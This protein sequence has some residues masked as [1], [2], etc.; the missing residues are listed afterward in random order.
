MSDMNHTSQATDFQ[1]YGEQPMSPRLPDSQQLQAQLMASLTPQ[2]TQGQWSGQLLSSNFETHTSSGQNQSVAKNRNS[3]DNCHQ[4]NVSNQFPT[5]EGSDNFFVTNLTQINDKS[6]TRTGKGQT[7]ATRRSQKIKQILSERL[8]VALDKNKLVKIAPK[9]S[10]QTEACSIQDAHSKSNG[11]GNITIKKPSIMPATASHNTALDI[12]VHVTDLPLGCHSRG[13]HIT[14]VS[15]SSSLLADLNSKASSETEIGSLHKVIPHNSN[16]I[17][18][19]NPSNLNSRSVLNQ[20]LPLGMIQT[21]PALSKVDGS[22][23]SRGHHLGIQS[24]GATHTPVIANASVLGETSMPNI[25]LLSQSKGVPISATSSTFSF[26]SGSGLKNTKPASEQIM[27]Q[28]IPLTMLQTLPSITQTTKPD[29]VN[30]GVTLGSTI[31]PIHLNQSGTTMS[32][33]QQVSNNITQLSPGSLS[34]MAL[35]NQLINSDSFQLEKQKQTSDFQKSNL[36]PSGHLVEVTETEFTTQFEDEMTPNN[37][38]QNINAATENCSFPHLNS[39]REISPHLSE[40]GTHQKVSNSENVM[41]TYQ[42]LQSVISSLINGLQGQ[43]DATRKLYSPTCILATN[44]PQP[45]ASNQ[46]GN[47]VREQTLNLTNSNQL[48]DIPYSLVPINS[49][50]IPISNS[51]VSNASQSVE[52]MKDQHLSVDSGNIMHGEIRHLPQHQTLGNQLGVES[53]LS[54][55]HTI[56]SGDQIIGHSERLVDESFLSEQSGKV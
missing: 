31:S 44:N 18:V 55:E 32:Q 47:L 54:D 29:V 33:P 41:V 23:A 45:N 20:I 37:L 42:Q 13:H 49:Q 35:V 51:S 53:T 12:P 24:I 1:T 2:Q 40:E 46:I 19:E 9:E 26:C 4:H 11:K 52:N 17:Q 30:T 28:I 10:S 34:V 36:A 39:Q 8:T 5:V 14:N 21:R 22:S 25:G 50:N 43:L 16:Q 7:K 27:A 6:K 38:K 15:T 48:S 56:S 3:L